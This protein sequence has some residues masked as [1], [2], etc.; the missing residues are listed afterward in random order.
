MCGLQ[1]DRDKIEKRSHWRLKKSNVL[2]H[3]F[4]LVKYCRVRYSSQLSLS[5][6]RLSQL[7]RSR[8]QLMIP[9]Y[10]SR[11]YPS[12]QLL[13]QNQNLRQYWRQMDWKLLKRRSKRPQ[14]WINS[15]ETNWKKT[16]TAHLILRSKAVSLTKD[17]TRTADL[18]LRPTTVAKLLSRFQ[19]TKTILSSYRTN[20]RIQT[21]WS[22]T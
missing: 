18:A 12:H 19:S 9:S 3:R 21:T 6:R 20:W 13:H 16:T 11:S 5:Y 1:Y 14:S 2:H 10:N 4:N 17:S 15:R 7:C 8:N 22:T